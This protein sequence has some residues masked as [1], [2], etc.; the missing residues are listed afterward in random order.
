MNRRHLIAALACLLLTGGGVALASPPF[1]TPSGMTGLRLCYS[2]GS[3]TAG[4]SSRPPAGTRTAA[5]PCH[6]SPPN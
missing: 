1:V 2:A 5:P 6:T 4:R 3:G